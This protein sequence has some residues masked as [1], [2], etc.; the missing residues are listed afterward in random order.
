MLLLSFRP[1]PARLFGVGAHMED[2]SDAALYQAVGLATVGSQIFERVFV[3]AVRF[4]VKQDNVHSFDEIKTVEAAAAFKQPTRALLKEI[5]GH[6]QI[7]HLEDRIS[8][9]IEDRHR[10]IHRL[11]EKGGWPGPSTDAQRREILELCT[12][13]RFESVSLNEALAPLMASWIS[14]FPEIK[15]P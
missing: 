7:E 6:A 8:R 3:V 4:A 15:L 11:T 14:R 10:V 9:L 5:S 1:W 2:L 12:R 13:V